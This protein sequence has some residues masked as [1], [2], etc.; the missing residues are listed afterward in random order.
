MLV[1]GALFLQGATLTLS[2]GPVN[3]PAEYI[4]SANERLPHCDTSLLRGFERSVSVHFADRKNGFQ[5]KALADWQ[6]SGPAQFDGVAFKTA[7]ALCKDCKLQ[8]SE[9]TLVSELAESS[10]VSSPATTRRA[11]GCVTRIISR[12]RA[13]QI[14]STHLHTCCCNIPTDIKKDSLAE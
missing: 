13:L 6:N 5:N 14:L 8:G 3:I 9:C 2:K 7:R 4:R 12:C 10:T 1:Y 11:A